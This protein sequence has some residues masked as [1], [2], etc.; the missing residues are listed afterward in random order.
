MTRI[1]RNAWPKALAFATAVL[2]ATPAFAGYDVPPPELSKVLKAP[3]PPS[4]SVDPTGRR[5]LLTTSQTYPSIERVARPYY[6]L[7]GV[8]LEPQNRSRHD[9]A[10]GYG[11]PAC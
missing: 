4:P 7:A 6:K 10:G 2:F 3:P 9:T 5:L 11:I 1:R 8:R